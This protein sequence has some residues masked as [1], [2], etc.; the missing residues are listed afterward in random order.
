MLKIDIGPI[1]VLIL[2][3]STCSLF[4]EFYKK[5]KWQGGDMYTFCVHPY[6]YCYFLLNATHRFGGH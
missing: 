6:K 5:E 4:I 3:Y 2:K 1:N